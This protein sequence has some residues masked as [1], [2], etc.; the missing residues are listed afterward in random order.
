M[1]LNLRARVFVRHVVAVGVI[2]ALAAL[3]GDWI[4]SRMVLGE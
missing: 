1:A 2:L 4:F 3:G